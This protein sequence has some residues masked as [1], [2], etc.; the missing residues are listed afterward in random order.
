[1]K[2]IRRILRSIRAADEH[3]TLIRPKE[4]IVI[5]VSGGKDSMVLLKALKEYR[6]YSQKDFEILPVFIDL[7]FGADPSPIAEYAEKLGFS[8]TIDDSRF[9]YGVLKEHQG[10]LAHLP[11]SICSRMKKAAIVSAAKKLGAHT[12]AF[13]HHADDAIETL[14]LNMI[15]GSRVATFSPKMELKRSNIRF[16]RPLYFARESDIS[17]MAKE[18]AIP[19]LASKCPADGY[20]DREKI[21]E[22]LE[23]FYE[24]NKDAK[25]NFL[26]MLLNADSFYLPFLDEENS[27]RAS[28]Y[29]LKVIRKEEDL[30]NSSFLKKKKKEGEKDYLILKKGKKVGEIAVIP[31]GKRHYELLHLEGEEEALQYAIDFLANK[32]ARAE[33]PLTLDLRAKKNL[34]EKAGFTKIFDSKRQKYTYRKVLS[35]GLNH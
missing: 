14:F 25:E 1:M 4:K 29:S 11:C 21:K 12:V 22:F 16:I 30:R 33:N 23:N 7:G 20:T 2:T 31:L 28:F 27:W 9:V 35:H 10:N 26:S 19:V 17:L 5:G 6:Y 13:A 8:L 32:L 34:A 15:H 3:F 24:E 18:E